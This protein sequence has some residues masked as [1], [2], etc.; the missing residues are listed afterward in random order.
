MYIELRGIIIDIPKSI[1][2]VRLLVRSERG[3]D[4]QW[5]NFPSGKPLNRGQII[6]FLG[7]QYDMEP[8]HIVWPDHVKIPSV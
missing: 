6:K 7:E 2:R 3:D 1:S 8:G 4:Y 5:F